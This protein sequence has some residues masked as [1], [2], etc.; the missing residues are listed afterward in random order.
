MARWQALHLEIVD[1]LIQSGVIVRNLGNVILLFGK[2]KAR[3]E[4][5]KIFRKKSVRTIFILCYPD[6]KQECFNRLKDALLK[7]GDVVCEKISH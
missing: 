6:G 7:A 5:R 2:R 4:K 3:I 1:K